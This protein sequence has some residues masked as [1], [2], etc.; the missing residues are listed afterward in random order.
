MEGLVVIALVAAFVAVV[1][2]AGLAIR[3]IWT[4]TEAP[5]AKP[6]QRES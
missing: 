6:S 2:V 5:P 1:V 4:A 3:R